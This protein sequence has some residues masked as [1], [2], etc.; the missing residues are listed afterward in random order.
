MTDLAVVP[1]EPKKLYWRDRE[2]EPKDISLGVQ[3]EAN[4]I[5]RDGDSDGSLLHVMAHSLHYVDDGKRVFRSLSQLREDV[6]QREYY[7]L[8]NLAIACSRHNSPPNE[9]L[10]PAIRQQ[11]EE[12][13]DPKSSPS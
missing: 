12:A 7:L 13:A 6:M 11:I 3:K 4:K 8:M 2:V 10:D 5:S 9:T 1:N